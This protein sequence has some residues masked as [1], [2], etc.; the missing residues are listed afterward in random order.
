[1]RYRAGMMIRGLTALLMLVLVTV[2]LPALLYRLGGSPIP[3]HLPSLHR[4]TFTL[5]HKDNGS[6]FLG[7][8]RDVSWL[9]W[10]AF[11]IAVLAETQAALRGR[12][13]PRLRL[14]GMQGVASRLV[15]AVALTFSTPA[16][17]ALAV[18]PA[19]A[20]TAHPAT[21]QA[22]REPA[23][24]PAHQVTGAT[25][26]ATTVVVQPGDCLWTLAQH[27]L[28]SGERFTAIVRL[29]LGHTMGHGEVFSD[30]SVIRPGWQLRMPAA[31][32]GGAALGHAVAGRDAGHQHGTGGRQGTGRSGGHDSSGAH[33]GHPSAD[34]RF[35]RAHRSAGHGHSAPATPGVTPGASGSGVTPGQGAGTMVTTSGQHQQLPELALFTL[36]MLAGGALATLERLRH[37]QRQY[38]RSGHRIAL[39]TDEESQRVESK[40]RA[41]ARVSLDRW[42]ADATAADGVDTEQIAVAALPT[43][44]AD[45]LRDLSE[46][47]AIAGDPLPPIVGI[48]L[49]ANTLDVLLSAPAVGPPPPPFTIAP[50]RQAMCWTTELECPAGP[51][52]TPMTPGEVGDLLPG[53]FTAGATDSGGYLLLDLEAMRVT[54]CDGPDDL[55]DRLLVTA[56]T[57]LASSRWSGWYDLILVGCDELDILGRAE[58]CA[59]L[60]DA[61]DLLDARAR[62]VDARLRDGGPPDVKGR[63]LADPEDE[64]WGLALLIS[65]VQPTPDQMTRLLD[66]ADGPGGIAALVAGDTQADDGKVAPALF[67]LEP[68]P[69]RPDEIVAMIS[70]ADLGHEHRIT[71]WPQT[72]TI[73]EYEALAGIF[74][75]AADLADVDPDADP[76]D[77]QAGPPWIR[78]SAAPVAPSDDEPRNSAEYPAAG[79]QAP[80]WD[81]PV[82][83]IGHVAG[84]RRE[85]AGEAPVGQWPGDERLNGY[86]D[87][88]AA[89]AHWHD[90]PLAYGRDDPQARAGDRSAGPWRHPGS[91]GPVGPAAPGPSARGSSGPG[92]SG[93]G[94]PVRGIEIKVL[95]PVEVLGAAE[96][97][98]PKQ[99]E[100]VLALAL[101]APVGLS[102]SALCTLLGAD[103]DHPRPTD[104][105]RQLITRTRRRLGQ[106]PD[107]QE[108]IVHL[109]SGIYVLHAA[110]RLDWTAFSSLATRGRA[111]ASTADLH[112]ALAMIKGQPF[113]DCFHWWIDISLV[114]TMRAEIVDAAELLANMELTAGDPRAA[115]RAARAGL[116]AEAASEQL[117]RALMCAEHDSGNLD[118]VTAA[119]NGCLDAI[120]E[121][122]PGADPH[123][124]TER[125]YRQLTRAVVPVGLRY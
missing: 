45:A 81:D 111:N 24:H 28:G 89:P 44:M 53:L 78:L 67:Q 93:P 105:V 90:D 118:G 60:D 47:V 103:N 110:A 70:I 23:M 32:P 120:S 80:G 97:L 59:D 37:R 41:A 11:V 42:A 86:H 6:L 96:P 39:P 119:W 100:L 113:A 98:Q 68:D 22:P 38:R 114:E 31:G 76:Y 109:G 123:P 74:A 79:R 17:L 40:L 29:N 5:M 83:H 51:G 92:S 10:A 18:A 84:A 71:V 52:P 69:D 99:A 34:P 75:T 107:G 112:A 115:A 1:M 87:K 72:L 101:H 122:A 65:R 25:A 104:S 57:E 66:L 8:V 2:G 20:A 19:M 50:A 82:R 63:R 36:G 117:W 30:P 12:R 3:T 58:L 35:R 46:A 64:D 4:I 15:A 48:H 21:P 54:C 13:A 61:L 108:Y 102:N 116:A 27:Y 85:P 106:A 125:L 14:A 88:P 16:V 33:E 7:A 121:I 55:T 73:A 62:A 124:D 95:G 26:E 9:A 56:A 77:G 91:A 49:T 43:T 94:S